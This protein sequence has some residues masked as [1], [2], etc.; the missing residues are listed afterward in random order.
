MDNNVSNT[1]YL[2]KNVIAFKQKVQ[3]IGHCFT[4]TETT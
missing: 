2:H 1:K 3:I 4:N